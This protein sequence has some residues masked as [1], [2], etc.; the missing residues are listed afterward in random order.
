M[1]EIPQNGQNDLIEMQSDLLVG[2]IR[3]YLITT[4]GRTSED[5]ALEE[6][7]RAFCHAL[8][9][10]MMVNWL[11]CHRTLEK[12]QCRVAYYLSLEYLPGRLLASSLVNLGSEA[13]IKRVFYKMN[14]N[15]QEIAS[16][17][18]D[19]ALG[20]GG[21]GRLASCMLDS[22][23][24]KQYPALGYGL[25]YQYGIF[26][27]QLW[28]GEQIEKPELWLM[29]QNPWEARRD[30]K[31]T[32][33][34]YG[35]H[36]VGEELR[37]PEEVS[38]TPYDL[39]IIGYPGKESFSVVTLRLWS[40]HDS[41]RNFQLQRYNAGRLDQAAENTTITDVLYPSDNNVTG[42]RI[43]LKQE[44]LLVSASTQDIL[45]RFRLG[46]NDISRFPDKVAIQINDTHAALIVTE[47]MD[48]LLKE[49]KLDWRTAWEITS[50]TVNYTNHT[51]LKEALE[52]WDEPL[53][54]HLVPRH[55]QILEQINQQLCDTVR[56][57]S[58]NNEARVQRMSI[59]EGGIV[60]MAHLAV[61]G[62]KKVNGVAKIHSEIL[63][64]EIFKDFSEIWPNKF[65]NVTN[66]VT[67]RRWILEANP[68]LAN[69][70][71]ERVGKGWITNFSEVSKLR[72]FASDLE[73]Q[74]SLLAIKQTNKENLA[75]WISKH[76]R[77]R[78]EEGRK[79]VLPLLVDPYSLFDMQV[80]RIHEYK[81]QILNVLHLIMV[82]QEIL[83]NPKDHGRLPRTVIF[84]GKAAAS[85][86]MAKDII[87]GIHC[88]A[89]TIRSHPVA[90]RFL[91]ILFLENY[92][93][94]LAELIIPCADL[95]E[96]LSLAG[97][98]ASG[99]GNMK[100]SMNG[101]LTIGTRD[102]ANI[103]MEESV[104]GKWWP[105][106]FGLSVTEVNELFRRGTYT[107]WELCSKDPAIEQAV[108]ALRGKVFSMNQKEHE[109]LC[110]LYDSL[111]VGHYDK[112]GDRYLVLK[113][114]RSYW[115]TQKKVE[116]LYRNP[117]SWAEYAIHNI[118]G[119]GPFSSDNT[120]QNYAEKIWHISPCPPDPAI[121]AE[122][123]RQ[124]SEHD[125]CRIL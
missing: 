32:T 54:R 7:Y 5:A 35:G 41:P 99:T 18:P 26:E 22:L 28:D 51:V 60:R 118:A 49:Y 66:G 29:D 98:E 75:D 123:H 100:L 58:P 89:R 17:E 13:L 53:M 121:L 86:A 59:L 61:Y 12:T 37:N 34:L 47:L 55:Y 65:T 70:I 36:L 112:P 44:F 8:S 25:R 106:V 6:F 50:Q 57:Y 48:R 73:S 83:A 108:E 109:L 87:H 80:K 42:R 111:M 102:G 97:Q 33:V 79:R 56:Y 52:E 3:H 46:N 78:D 120:V 21:L 77:L 62:S 122:V 23:A 63:K 1:L 31:K 67:Q 101:A 103:E 15:F 84:A 40:T 110:R 74:R 105:F 11:S 76:H 93:V 19:P 72:D 2:K 96:Q 64:K 68:L 30:L 69:W 91:N 116:E 90:N 107:P 14:R 95:S 85:Y 38:A 115:E 39:P 113:D 45:R 71:T 114:L 125:R 104:G 9:E 27:Q 88:I 92:N 117:S 124:Y 82:Y 119:M 16:H 10:E 20:N 81:R 94:S 43:R 24:S 4:M